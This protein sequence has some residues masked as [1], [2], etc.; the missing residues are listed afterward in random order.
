MEK[1]DKK[2]SILSAA[3][4]LFSELGYE[5]TSTRLIAKEAGANMSMIN[6]YFGS[7]EGVFIEIMN[8]RIKFFNTQLVS[9]SEYRISPLEKLMKVIEEYTNRILCNIS[10]HKMMHRELSLAQRP[11]MYCKLKDAIGA[12]LNAIENIIN[13]GIEANTFRKV[14]VRMLISTIMGTITSVATTPSKITRG[15]TLD[16]TIPKDR[17]ILTTRLIVHLKDLVTTYLTP[18]K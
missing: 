15:S 17:E 13:E 1:Q 2:A 11:E 18:Q 12:N 10:F 6:Y 8:E 3:E 5:G 14:D 4:K 7:K 16:I 9:I